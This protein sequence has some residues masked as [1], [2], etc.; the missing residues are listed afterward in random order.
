MGKSYESPE[1]VALYEG[2][3]GGDGTIG[4]DLTQ[5]AVDAVKNG[6]LLVT[7]S[8][9]MALY[10]GGGK[11]PL[12]LPF[13][14]STQGFKELAAISHL[15]PAM[16]SL[17]ELKSRFDATNV[18]R[19]GAEDLRRRFSAARESNSASLWRDRISVVAYRGR[20]A[21]IAA[22]I[23]YSCGVTQ[24]LLDAVLLDEQKLDAS[25]VR[26][27]Y[28]EGTGQELH[29]VVP[30]NLVMIATFFLVGMD[31]SYRTIDW[32]KSQDLDWGR[33]MV[34][35]AGQQ[36]RPTAG[37]TW[38]SNSIAQII[39]SAS[40]HALPLD[41]L[42][43]APHAPT[44]KTQGTD[45]LQPV[46]DVEAPLRRL[47]A[48]TRAIHDLGEVMFEGYPAF[49]PACVLIPKVTSDTKALGEMPEIHDAEDV[50]AMT[51][52]LRL[53]L[54]DPRQLLS[55]CVTDFAAEQLASNGNNPQR[56]IVP[57]LDGYEYPV[58]L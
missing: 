15:G 38:T 16:A 57:G 35:V 10:P 7:T 4:S 11:D 45:D 33:T 53:V 26:R 36:G 20:E 17:V 55:G 34:I 14:L 1:L 32:L 51:T 5:L 29:A 24:R 9:D 3:T 46:R 18:W 50:R 44:F 42:Y 58:G 41:R 22:M 30:F 12:L 28:L 39:V 43:I 54:E 19:K 27:E 8:T 48:Y 13:R 25:F 2:Y 23:D 47:W 52:R 49:D 56:V 21:A 40:G 37:V 31:I 6:P